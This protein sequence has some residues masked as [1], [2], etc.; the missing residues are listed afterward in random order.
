MGQTL[1]CPLTKAPSREGRACP[2]G[3]V[4]VFVSSDKNSDAIDRDLNVFTFAFAVAKY[5]EAPKRR[6]AS[7]CPT[8]L[9]ITEQN[10]TCHGIRAWT[11]KFGPVQIAIDASL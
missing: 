6:F 8:L 2:Q 10:G 5:L 7:R 3:L 4:D 1:R 9:Q 11:P